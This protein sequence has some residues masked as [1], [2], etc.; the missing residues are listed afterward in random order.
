MTVR[1]LILAAVFL[2]SSLVSVNVRADVPDIE[3]GRLKVVPFPK[4]LPPD[5][6]PRIVRWLSSA[7]DGALTRAN[8]PECSAASFEDA[9]LRGERDLQKRFDACE[10]HL[11][12]WS[13]PQFW[14]LLK[15]VAVEYDLHNHRRIREV[16]IGI[17]D[18]VYRR[19]LLAMRPGK[20]P[21]VIIQCGLFCDVYDIET[22]ILLMHLYDGTPFHV[23]AV[24]S[25]T[26]V[27]YL[28]SGSPLNLGG[29]DEGQQLLELIDLLRSPNE[30]IS[31]HI[32]SIHLAGASL[33]A[34]AVFYSGL[35]ASARER[36]PLASGIALCPV[37]NYQGA[38]ENLAAGG[39]MARALGLRAWDILRRILSGAEDP[40]LRAL[41]KLP[42]TQLPRMVEEIGFRQYAGRSGIWPA[43]FAELELRQR[44]DF[45]SLGEFERHASGLKVPV[46][47]WASRD[48]SVVLAEQNVARLSQHPYV[49]TLMSRSGLHCA[50][51]SY[52]GWD[53]AT[54]FLRGQILAHSGSFLE[55][56]VS[57]SLKL[58]ARA[59]LYDGE[60]FFSYEW[61]AKKKHLEL[62]L[63]I[64][65]PHERTGNSRCG[66]W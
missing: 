63:K 66:D 56:R 46:F 48:D 44:A 35:Y 49:N 3:G 42:P 18:N 15:F 36:S 12:R 17:R 13:A 22:K 20:R 65:N 2:L 43:P 31:K 19:G 30:P 53:M 33:G 7:P 37:V 59:D 8:K 1:A 21:L 32:S 14:K 47:A 40:D 9:V 60:T 26:G 29:F 52:Y 61:E 38:V 5:G 39:A 55:K 11:K 4:E 50:A 45:W 25:V 62:R 16:R 24:G 58:D 27:D 10:K 23:L 51:P 28:R 54:V 41:A 57:R 34:H 64:W 6:R